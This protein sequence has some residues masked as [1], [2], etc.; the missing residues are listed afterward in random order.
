MLNSTSRVSSICFGLATLTLIPPG[1]SS[2]PAKPA[3]VNV[4]PAAPSASAQPTLT[5]P[6]AATQRTTSTYAPAARPS[7]VNRLAPPRTAPRR[8][9]SD[10]AAL[11]SASVPSDS[12]TDNAA[13]ATSLGAVQ[14]VSFAT[15]GSDFDPCVSRDGTTVVFA[16]TQHRQT[17]DIYS[18]AVAGRTVTRLTTDPA[19]DVMPAISPDGSKIAFCSN[20]NGNWDIFI[21]PAAGGKAVQLT[22]ESS[23]ELH[24]SWSPDGSAIVFCRLGETSGRWE[25]WVADAVNTASTQFIGYG[26]F[27]QWSPVAATGANGADRILFQ[28]SRERGTR[29]FGV[30]TIDYKSGHAYNATEIVSSAESALINPTWSPDGANI[31][32]AEVPNLEDWDDLARSLPPSAVLWAQAVDGSGRI[33]LT[34]GKAVALM[35][36]WSPDNRVFFVSNRNGP[37]TIWSLRVDENVLALLNR[38]APAQ[39]AEHAGAGAGAAPS[40]DA[41]PQPA[42]PVATGAEK[43]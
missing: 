17:S 41:M 14:Q 7:G 35:P 38:A 19:D 30:W 18:K 9:W 2:A 4:P 31:A 43:H 6:T 29:T 20:R 15:E 25:L 36:F 27:P 32:Y 39:A 8:D 24:P 1:C 12:S 40:H 16:S 11:G 23:H 42:A 13:A 5:Q 34:G 28:L 37:E 21:M 3:V 33:A 22:S 26:V 10:V